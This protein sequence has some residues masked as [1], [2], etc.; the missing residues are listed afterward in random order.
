MCIL[1]IKSGIHINNSLKIIG[2]FDACSTKQETFAHQPSI[3]SFI[4]ENNDH[5]GM[6]TAPCVPMVLGTKRERL[7]DE[8]VVRRSKI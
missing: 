4:V 1:D 3:T 7:P 5:Q 2:E 8:T 6:V